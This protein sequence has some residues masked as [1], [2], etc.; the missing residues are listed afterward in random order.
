MKM[1]NN[2]K[3]PFVSIQITN[4]C[5][6]DCPFC[7]RRNVIDKP[8]SN[9]EKI[10]RN[11]KDCNVDT[12]VISGGEPLLRKDIV[13]I[14]ELCK[15]LNIKTVLQSNGILLNK[16][17]DDIYK[18]VD[19]ISLSLDGDTP[20]TNSLLRSEKQFYSILKILPIIKKNKIK[21]KLGT[22]VTRI[23]YE[24]ILG[25]GKLIGNYVDIWKLYQFYPRK[26]TLADKNKD[27]LAIDDELFKDVFLKIKNNFPNMQ[28][29]VHA[30]KDFNKSPCLMI[31]PDGKVYVTKENKDFLI[32]DILN[33]KDNFIKNY[34]KIEIVQE[35]IKNYNKTYKD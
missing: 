10:I 16:Y 26:G 33:A 11:L 31:D 30:V 5:N 20:E 8:F 25:I 34:E 2:I 19:W 28:I 1:K 6:L 7:F 12:I 35:I 13:E 3:I 21:V 14:L 9:I 17:F 18:Y 22:V 15:E 29:S 23:N 24:N 32:G 4:I 27:K